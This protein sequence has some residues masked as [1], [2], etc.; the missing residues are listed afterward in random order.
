MVLRQLPD[1][2]GLGGVFEAQGAALRDDEHDLLQHV[3]QVHVVGGAHPGE[4]LQYLDALN[5]E[6][7]GFR[8]LKS[9]ECDILGDGMLDYSDE[10]LALFDLVIVSIHS[11]F[12]MTQAE[13][14]ERVLRAMSNPF[15]TIVGHLTGRLLLARE[16]YPIDT[17]RILDAA[18]DLGVSLEL[19]ANPHRL[20]LDWRWLNK[21]IDRGVKISIN[22]DAHRIDGLQDIHYGV[23]IARK[24]WLTASDVLNCQSA[25]DLLSFAAQ[26]R[27]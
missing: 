8:V 6:L 14:T 24:G 21:A 12:K 18:A 25:E 23:R 15:V 22:P 16:G 13:A 1:V 10:I 17:G 7:N 4:P 26:R 3:V 11:R 5:K 9:I 20:D 27:G 2:G 19:N